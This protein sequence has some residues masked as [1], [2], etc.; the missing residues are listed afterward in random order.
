[1]I[2]NEIIIS[3][4]IRLKELDAFRGI[5][6][7]VVVLF[8]FSIEQS[9]FYI[10]KSGVYFFFIISGF[11][12]FMTLQKIKSGKEFWISRIS[13]LYPAYWVACILIIFKQIIVLFFVPN[14]FK[15]SLINS[16]INMTMFQS[17]FN[18]TDLNVVFWTLA[19]EFQFYILIFFFYKANK[20]N[21]IK[22]IGFIVALY[23]LAL[24]FLIPEFYKEIHNKLL[25][26]FYFPLFV[27][28]IIFYESY[29]NKKIS[30][31]NY[32]YLFFF[33]IVQS[34]ILLKKF[35]EDYSIIY[36]LITYYFLFMTYVYGKIE[37][38]ANR[39]LLFLGKISYSLYL[40][41]LIFSLSILKVVSKY[42]NN[43]FGVVIALIFSVV[44]AYLMTEYIENPLSK[45]IAKFLKK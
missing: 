29:Q 35:N 39:F 14:G 10:G 28:G 3:K 19:V 4:S 17:Y 42:T 16:F 24:I 1:M 44:F 15:I 31:Q 45:K 13:R 38:I 33:I 23:G 25:L 22:Y 2:E 9:F 5:A 20:I 27:S 41:H 43:F 30:F 12:I 8:H 36:P 34:I 32:I 21:Y 11:V 7:F 40:S 37:F 18:I 6:S 26:I